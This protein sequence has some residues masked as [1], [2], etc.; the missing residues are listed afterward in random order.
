MPDDTGMGDEGAMASLKQLKSD[1]HDDEEEHKRGLA[2]LG[3]VVEEGEDHVVPGLPR[4]GACA[5]DEWLSV[6]VGGGAR[7]LV[8]QRE[9]LAGVLAVSVGAAG[10]LLAQ[11]FTQ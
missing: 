3:G 6:A 1:E 2:E 7:V 8:P 9:V 11:D 4:E 5:A 10:H